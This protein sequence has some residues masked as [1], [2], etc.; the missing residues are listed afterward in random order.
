MAIDDLLKQ[1]NEIK[2]RDTRRKALQA[3]KD[4]WDR[5]T[6]GKEKDMTLKEWIHQNQHYL[7]HVDIKIEPSD[8]IGDLITAK[9]IMLIEMMSKS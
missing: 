6:S 9:N 2:N 3:L 7:K 4:S 5:V 1:V 8:D